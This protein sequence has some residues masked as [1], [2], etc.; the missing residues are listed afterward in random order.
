MLLGSLFGQ[1]VVEFVIRP[2]SVTD[3][4]WEG[5]RPGQL[6]TYRSMA[7]EPMMILILPALDMEST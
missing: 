2:D 6:V 7:G 3:R 4:G 1:D 5:D